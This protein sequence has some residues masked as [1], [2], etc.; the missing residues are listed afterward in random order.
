MSK[1]IE[2]NINGIAL[3]GRADGTYGF[4]KKFRDYVDQNRVYKKV[5]KNPYCMISSSNSGAWKFLIE[6]YQ[7][8]EID[9]EYNIQ[10]FNISGT[11]MD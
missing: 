6:N 5:D 11:L 7:L 1:V 2:V 3:L 8:G 10:S 4:Q 9:P